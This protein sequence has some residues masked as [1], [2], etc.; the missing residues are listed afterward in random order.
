MCGSDL[1]CTVASDSLHD[2]ASKTAKHVISVA[3]CAFIDCLR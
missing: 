2:A 1:L 3:E